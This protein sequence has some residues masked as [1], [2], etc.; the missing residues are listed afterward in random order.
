MTPKQENIDVAER[1]DQL[2]NDDEYT[3]YEELED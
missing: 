1:Q 2:R 3:S